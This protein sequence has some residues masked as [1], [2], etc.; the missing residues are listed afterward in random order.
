MKNMITDLKQTTFHHLKS[1]RLEELAGEL[2]KRAMTNRIYNTMDWHRDSTYQFLNVTKQNYHE[3]E[4][5]QDWVAEF[6]DLNEM[7]GARI[8]LLAL[9]DADVL[10]EGNYLI[11]TFPED[12]LE[13]VDP[14]EIEE[15]FRY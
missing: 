2:F 14:R 1:H 8:F 15:E 3:H 11:E 5:Y 4:E 13:F 10:P 7:M 12:V 6:R 9:V